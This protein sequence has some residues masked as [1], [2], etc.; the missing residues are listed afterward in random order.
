MFLAISRIKTVSSHY[1]SSGI[2]KKC[3][4]NLGNDG[5]YNCTLEHRE[6]ITDGVPWLHVQ[7]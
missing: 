5:C 6:K 2:L 3:A 4:K 7:E 1:F